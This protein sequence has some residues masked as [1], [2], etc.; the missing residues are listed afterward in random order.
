MAN[1][2]AQ[3]NEIRITRA[4]YDTVYQGS[5]V[6][7]IEN[8]GDVRILRNQVYIPATDQAVRELKA[9][10]AYVS[11]GGVFGRAGYARRIER[12][13]DT[14]F[15]DINA[16]HRDEQLENA[17]NAETEESEDA[18]TETETEPVKAEITHLDITPKR[19]L[20]DL[21]N[22]PNFTGR[23][24]WVTPGLKDIDRTLPPVT[25]GEE[26]EPEDV[27]MWVGT[28]HYPTIEEFVAE[29]REHGISKRIGRV[30]KGIVPGISRLFLAHDEGI[31]G[32]AVIF[33]YAI[34]G[35]VEM[36]TDGTIPA[37][38]DVVLVRLEDAAEE[39]ERGCGHRDTPGALYLATPG[40]A[41]PV[42]TEAGGP[43]VTIHGK[44]TV[45]NEPRD[46]NAIID[47]DATR[48]RSVMKV[49]GNEIIASDKTKSRPVERAEDELPVEIPIR[50]PGQSWDDIEREALRQ[51]IDVSPSRAHAYR[52][53]AR[54]TNRSIE[55]CAYQ[56]RQHIR[57]GG[58]E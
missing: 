33:G 45:F 32:D 54:A 9:T 49:D 55:A 10:A 25:V 21:E 40:A 52:T 43:G 11:E 17:E 27:L 5:E 39:P 50:E 12:L 4:F 56:D 3:T 23:K 41:N 29:A 7:Q 47:E 46:Y 42:I 57:N 13:L 18:E 8:L 28:T 38:E 31:L 30:P 35:Q 20:E 34:I 48:F 58:V 6:G 22:D 53:F 36:L 2:D 19:V 44:L 24:P 15:P 37:P 26:E 1:Y 16:F 51:L 14:E